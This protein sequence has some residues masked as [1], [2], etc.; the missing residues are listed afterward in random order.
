MELFQGIK[1]MVK[2]TLFLMISKVIIPLCERHE[3]SRQ[4]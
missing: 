1:Y 4:E 3:V 2:L